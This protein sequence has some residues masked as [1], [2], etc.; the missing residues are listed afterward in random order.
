M[1]SSP[2]KKRGSLTRE[3]ILEVA[4]EQFHQ[5]G[6]D[7]TS[8]DDVAR[9]LS[10]TKPSLYY[11]FENKED[12]LKGCVTEAAQRLDAGLAASDAPALCGRERLEIFLREYLRVISDNFG[13]ALVLG[14][15]RVMS[16]EGRQL[17]FAHRRRINKHVTDVVAQGT[18]DGSIASGDVTLTVN[19]IFGMFNWIPRWR[20]PRT[21]ASLE[22]IHA[23]FCAILFSGLAPPKRRF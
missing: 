23:R 18:R 1:P 19:A 11:H 2:A 15:D 12:I 10:V 7:R 13:V 22:Q 5:K 17:Y 8:L 21:R 6:Y 20:G 9:A 14:D 4:S 3:R 16:D